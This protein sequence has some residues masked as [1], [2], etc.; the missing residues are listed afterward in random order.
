[1]K[2]VNIF[3]T[4]Q[5]FYALTSLPGTISEHIRRAIEEYVVKRQPVSTS[6]SKRKEANG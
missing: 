1:M 4:L 2:R 5:Q 6:Q 3:I